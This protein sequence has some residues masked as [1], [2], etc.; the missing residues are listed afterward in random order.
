MTSPWTLRLHFRHFFRPLVDQQHHQVD[1]G[2][3]RADGVG[4]V[5][6]QHRFAGPRRSDDQRPLPLADR[7]QQVHHP[8]RDGLRPGFELDLLERI[9]RPSARRST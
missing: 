7:R 8:H 1:F 6:Q 5:L 4:D 9:D 2:M 3:I